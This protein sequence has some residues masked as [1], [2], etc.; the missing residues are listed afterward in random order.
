VGFVQWRDI[1][2]ATRR[3]RE[4]SSR[5]EDQISV[6]FPDGHLRNERHYTQKV[7]G[8]QADFSPTAVA[9]GVFAVF[10]EGQPRTSTLLKLGTGIRELH[11]KGYEVR[12]FWNPVSPAHIV[13]ARHHFPVLFQGAIDAIDQLAAT[14]P[15]DRYVS[16]RESLDAARFS[17]TDADFFDTTHAD[18]DCIRRM[19]ASSFVARDTTAGEL[20]RSGRQTGLLAAVGR[21]SDR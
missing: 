5:L 21:P 4:A 6:W 7:A 16:A 19:F 10:N 12:A 8:L 11:E 13:A 1:V 9:D 20:G 3:R 18:L 17:C 15:L 2:E 14:L